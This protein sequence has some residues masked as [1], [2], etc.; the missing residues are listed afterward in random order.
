MHSAKT[1]RRT[2][3]ALIYALLITICVVWLIP[4]LLILLQSL[5]AERYGGMS[6][7][8]LP[9][10][11]GFKNYVFLFRQTP[12]P[13]WYRNTLVIALASALLQTAMV[14]IS[15]ICAYT[16]PTAAT[17]QSVLEQSATQTET[18]NPVN[19]QGF[20]ASKP[21]KAADQAAPAKAPE[22]PATPAK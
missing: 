8:V 11:W 6:G 20:G 1:K 14:I 22:A 16:A 4:F 3:N 9:R 7:Y 2:I 5:R 13:L 18:T 21:A 15:V 19:T 12:F 10:V 17:E